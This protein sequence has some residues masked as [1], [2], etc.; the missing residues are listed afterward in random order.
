MDE[1]EVLARHRASHRAF[2]RLF[3]GASP[4][5]EVVERDDGILHLV[6][7]ARPERSLVNAV[8]Y[9]DGAPLIGALDELAAFYDERAID[10]WTVWV[11]VGDYEVAEACR[12]A[13]HTLDATPELMWSP[14][15]ALD[16]APAAVGRVVSEGWTEV[17]PPA[18][19]VELDEAPPWK[20]VGDINDAAYGLPP[21]HLSITM[22]GVD[23]GRCLRTV[24]RLDARPVATATVNVVGEDAHVLLVATLPEARGRRLAEACMRNALAR[25]RERGATTTTLEATAMGRPVYERMGY[26]ALGALGMWERRRA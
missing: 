11:H 8:V 16:L 9:E 25:A 5:A 3:A 26:R 17:D 24:A 22:H 13:G 4:G 14:L 7:P 6:C 21:D 2:H 15:D 10:A 20:L 23:P 18:G 1:R 19:V 12:R